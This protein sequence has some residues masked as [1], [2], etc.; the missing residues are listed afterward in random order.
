LQVLAESIVDGER[1][2]ERSDSGGNSGDR[3]PR[4]YANDGLLALGAKISGCNKKFEA[5]GEVKSF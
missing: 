3:N 1:N 2:H 5:H 4:D